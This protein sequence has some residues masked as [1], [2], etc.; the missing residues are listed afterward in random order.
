MRP[1]HSEDVEN[2]KSDSTRGY[3]FNPSPDHARHSRNRLDRNEHE[4][5]WAALTG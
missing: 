2:K 1:L 3:Y 4:R 5:L